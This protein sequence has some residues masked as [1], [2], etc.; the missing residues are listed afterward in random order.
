MPDRTAS[1]FRHGRTDWY[2]PYLFTAFS[3]EFPNPLEYDVTQN[4]WATAWNYAQ[5]TYTVGTTNAPWRWRIHFPLKAAPSGDATLTLAFAASDQSRLNVYVN[6][7]SKPLTVVSP[8]SAGGNALIR[9]AIHA[10][11]G[12]SYVAIPAARLKAGPNTISLEQASVHGGFSHFMY[13]YLNL[14]T[15]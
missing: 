1:E 5:T 10:K 3:N 9:E 2:T 7:E 11:Y 13:D 6:D 15:P 4:D 8:P 12:L 14:E